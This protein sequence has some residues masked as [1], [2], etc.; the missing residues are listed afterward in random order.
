MQMKP[1]V[2]DH[3]GRHFGSKPL[4][5]FG[6]PYAPMMEAGIFLLFCWLVCFWLYRQ[7]FFIKV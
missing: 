4:N 1:W 7:K 2:R 6:A 3:F 5:V